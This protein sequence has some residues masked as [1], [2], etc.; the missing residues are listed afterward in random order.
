MKLTIL[1]TACAATL[2]ACAT[3]NPTENIIANDP[4]IGKDLWVPL[5]NLCEQPD[6]VRGNC[7]HVQGPPDV[8]LKIDGTKMGT[9]SDIYYHVALDDGRTGYALATLV[10]GHAT[11]MSPEECKRRGEPRIGM[12]YKQVEA[13]CWGKPKDVN[14]TQTGNGVTDQLVY[15]DGHYVYL[16]NGIVTGIQSGTAGPAPKAK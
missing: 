7:T 1:I 12:T 15:T 8:H 3:P 2:A 9:L 16:R 10:L 11:E 13:T 14:R 5:V 4:F 6:I